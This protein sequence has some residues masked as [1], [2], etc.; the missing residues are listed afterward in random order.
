[1]K[2]ILLTIFASSLF[3]VGSDAG[4]QES[5]KVLVTI[6]ISAKTPSFKDQRLVVM[7]YHNFPTQDD[8]GDKAVDRHIDAKFSHEQ[9]KDT[10]LTLTLGEKAM[11]NRRVQYSVN[12]SVY[13]G[14]TRTH[15]G[16]LDGTEAPFN[17][18]TNGCPSKLTLEVR[19]VP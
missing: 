1:M 7:Q 9:G 14:G 3:L 8:R 13:D 16:E 10:I 18:L 5:A 12:A 2:R 19:P 15:R 4:A 11:L 17:V 6:K